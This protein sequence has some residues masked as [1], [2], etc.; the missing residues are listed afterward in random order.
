MID[1]VVVVVVVMVVVVASGP[2]V[3][4]K[5]AAGGSRVRLGSRRG[6]AGSSGSPPITLIIAFGVGGGGGP[7]THPRRTRVNVG[8][9]A[10][11]APASH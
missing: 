9:G 1:V 5:W 8:G 11:G 2:W 7:T 10:L 3:G 6:G 4:R